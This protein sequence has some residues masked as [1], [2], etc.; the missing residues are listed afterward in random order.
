MLG[1]AT[2]VANLDRHFLQALLHGSAVN[3]LTTHHPVGLHLGCVLD[4]VAG[5]VLVQAESTGLDGGLG[6]LRE[7][8]YTE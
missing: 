2:M 8:R 7:K 6:L 3:A 4:A 1:Y 5:M